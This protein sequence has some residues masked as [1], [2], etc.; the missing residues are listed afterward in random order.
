MSHE[1]CILLENLKILHIKD[2]TLERQ[3]LVHAF[4]KKRRGYSWLYSILEK[5]L[6]VSIVRLLIFFVGHTYSHFSVKNL[7]KKTRSQ[8]NFIFIY[9]NK[10]EASVIKHFSSEVAIV[11]LD[12]S[13]KNMIVNTFLA[14]KNYRHLLEIFNIYLKKNNEVPF[15]QLYGY[16]RACEMLHFYFSFKLLFNSISAQ[17]ILVST[18]GNPHGLAAIAAGQTL[19]KEVVFMAHA[20]FPLNGAPLK[21]NKAL[22][23]GSAASRFYKKYGAIFEDV[24]YYY[25]KPPLFRTNLKNSDLRILLAPSK[26]FSWADMD[27]IF[28]KTDRCLFFIRYHPHSINLNDCLATQPSFVKNTTSM[29]LD[30]LASFADAVW[31]ANSN[32]HLDFISRGTPSF[33]IPELD[34]TQS[35]LLPFI[36]NDFL[37]NW[38]TTTS[39]NDQ[40][41]NFIK[42]CDS[43]KWQALFND[44]INTTNKD[45]YSL[46]F[47]AENRV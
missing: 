46:P 9:K 38:S 16:V 24:F 35:P 18:D 33:Y 11:S 17:T 2:N 21:V 42:N 19:Q 32:V 10:N 45:I 36:K 12:C 37:Q 26:S 5:N 1:H 6:H 47:I 23:F 29:D 44:Y 31:A 34:N 20:H 27:V 8:E 4:L 39:A 13:L 40:I 15:S 7:L 43:E 25:Q 41:V 14:L 3:D 30:E 28:K 22:F